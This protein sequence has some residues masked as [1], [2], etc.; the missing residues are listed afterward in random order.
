MRTLRTFVNFAKKAG[1]L[2]F[3]MLLLATPSSTQN[4]PPIAEQ[5]AKTYGL[6]QFGQIDAIRY[7]FNLMSPGLN[8][9]RSWIW[10]PKANRVTFE[11]KDKS[12]KPV[13]ATYVRS[14]IDTQP[15]AVKNEI[16]P[17]FVNDQYW[18]VFPFHVY[19]DTGAEVQD[20]GQQKLHLGKGTAKK[21]VV[22]YAG[23][24][25]SPGDTWEIYLGA[26][27]RVEELAF[28]HGGTAKP[29]LVLATWSGYKKAGPL[30]FSTE[31][32][33]TADGKVMHLFFSDVA[34]KLAGSDAWVTAQ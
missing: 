32:R 25:Y 24:G 30:L 27:N 12:G 15:D 33:G 26:D 5:L 22:K 29:R 18:L 3:A 28:H 23:G 16:D 6:D 20:A 17:G 34:V 9:T 21:V 2:I 1:V 19:W 8:L 10:E 7:T 11:G 14:Q 31:H 4:R 13:K